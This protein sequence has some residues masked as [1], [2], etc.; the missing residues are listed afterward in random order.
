[1]LP[2]DGLEKAAIVLSSLRPDAAEQ[3]LA[4]M[5]P[6]HE[7][8]LRALMQSLDRSSGSH[9]MR[10][11]VLLEFDTLLR[12]LVSSSPPNGGANPARTAGSAKFA[13]RSSGRLVAATA[14]RDEVANA[15]GFDPVEFIRL[16]PIDRLVQVLAGET[17]RTVALTLHLLDAEPAGEVLK[18]LEPGL[19][20]NVSPFLAEGATASADLAK[21]GSCLA[22]WIAAVGRGDLKAIIAVHAHAIIAGLREDHPAAE[23]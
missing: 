14:R 7:E 11:Q 10:G 19:R 3:I 21:H 5:A 6:E 15:E 2:A 8:R 23:H 12:A 13:E 18:R 20:R 17:P 1:M 9:S 16:M 4:R 22:E